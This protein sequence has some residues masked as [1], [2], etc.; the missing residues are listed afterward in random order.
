MVAGMLGM[1]GGVALLSRA[2]GGGSYAADLLP[3]LL[4][5]GLAVPL[6]FLTVS[7]TALESAGD[8]HA[9]LASGLV[10]TSQ[11]LGGAVGIALA[12]AISA[13]HS[14]GLRAAGLDGAAAVAGGVQAGLLGCAALGVAGTALALALLRLPTTAPAPSAA[15]A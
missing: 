6:L 13:A 14:D 9:G 11:C 4:V 10:N 1:T 3:G 15:R 7:M 5:L 2:P 8:E 12:S